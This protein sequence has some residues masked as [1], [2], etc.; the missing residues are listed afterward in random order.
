MLKK[1]LTM[2]DGEKEKLLEEIAKTAKYYEE[3]YGG[4]ARN[5]LAAL[6][7]YLGLCDDEKFDAVFQ[8][9]DALTGGIAYT[10]QMCGAVV[11]GVM[12]M[13]LVY[14]PDKLEPLL[15][16][17]PDTR[18]EPVRKHK[19]AVERG[20]AFVTR[21]RRE[22]GGITC[23][24]VQHKVTGRYWDLRNK[25]DWGLFITKPFHDKCGI[26]TGKA[27]RLAAKVILEP[28]DKFI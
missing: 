4:C 24:D 15:P 27:A 3:E 19:E 21:F 12:A 16:Q 26:V 9:A 10:Q 18:P 23:R 6:Q 8:S 22:F 17:S 20:H 7:K 1:I 11:A 28:S 13:G 2:S 5:P 14:G 25:D